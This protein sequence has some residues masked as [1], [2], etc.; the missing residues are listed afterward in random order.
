MYRSYCLGTVEMNPIGNH[1]VAGSIH[2][3]T[4]WVKDSALP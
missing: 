3:L 1:E 2:G 4:Q